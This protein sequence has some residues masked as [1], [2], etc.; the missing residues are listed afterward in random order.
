VGAVLLGLA[1]ALGETVAI[2]FVLNLIFDDFN[3]FRII[4]PEGG[5]IASLILS[6]FGEA[7]DT[8]I[9]ALL[10]AGVVLF[11]VTLLINTIASFI[12]AKAQPWNNR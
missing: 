5:A 1:R 3:W 9:S 4:S 11:V 8:E 6:K 2:F 7:S 12:V 10:A